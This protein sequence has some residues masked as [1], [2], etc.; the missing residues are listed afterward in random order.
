MVK[1]KN[2]NTGSIKRGKTF[3]WIQWNEDST[4]H[5]HH[6]KPEVGMSLI[7]DPN[8]LVYTW[9]TSATVEIIFESENE[10][11]FKTKNSH[12]KLLI[13]FEK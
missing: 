10:V 8:Q 2:L 1:L 6:K 11:E 9:L 7:I 3:A 5:S 12:Y 13:T 4:F